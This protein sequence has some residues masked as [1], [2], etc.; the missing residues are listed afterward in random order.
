MERESWM[1]ISERFLES[2]Y[3]ELFRD[4]DKAQE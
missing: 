2:D 4:Y 1:G 3:R